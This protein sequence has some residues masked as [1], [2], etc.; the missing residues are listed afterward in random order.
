[1]KNKPNRIYELRR[2]RG[3]SQEKLAEEL[4]VTQSS[5]SMYENGSNIPSD[6]L[7][8]ISK[9]F[10]VSIEY[11][12]RLTDEKYNIPDLSEKERNII[13]LYRNLS[14]RERSICDRIVNIIAETAT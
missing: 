10:G 7:I 3:I 2:S 12:L 11:L 5:V 1:M 6:I 9:Y 4:N 13:S 14:F 8:S